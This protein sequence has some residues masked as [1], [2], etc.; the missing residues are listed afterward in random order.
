MRMLR[1]EYTVL[2]VEIRLYACKFH[3]PIF[4]MDSWP[5]SISIIYVSLDCSWTWQPTTKLLLDDA[6][7]LNDRLQTGISGETVKL[8][9]VVG[10]IV[11]F[12]WFCGCAF[13]PDG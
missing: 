2:A 10:S 7:P 5:I 8:A 13:V 6:E 1:A 12:R 3:C 4:R 9:G 11:R